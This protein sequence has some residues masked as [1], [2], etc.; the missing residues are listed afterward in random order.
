MRRTVIAVVFAA[1]CEFA[2]KT[3]RYADAIR[4]RADRMDMW[5]ARHRDKYRPLT[6]QELA[7][8]ARFFGDELLQLDQRV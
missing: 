5:A 7:E 6:P 1:L 4:R 8:I 3:S 2:G